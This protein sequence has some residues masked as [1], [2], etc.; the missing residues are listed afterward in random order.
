MRVAVGPDQRDDIDPVAADLLHHVAEDG[1]R[2]DGLDLVGG[3]RAARKTE[4]TV[5][6]PVQLQDK[7][8]C[9]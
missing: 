7:D 4:K 3:F 9:S 8:D 5:Q 1:E 6:A 2:G